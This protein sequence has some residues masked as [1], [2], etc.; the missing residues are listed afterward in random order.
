MSQ[1]DIFFGGTPHFP[2][3]RTTDPRSSHEA[4][5]LVERTGI[6]GKQASAVLAA[7]HGLDNAT[8]A[9]LAKHAG[10][11]RYMVARRAP[12]LA[13]V[14]LID[15]VL[16]TQDTVPCEVSGKRVVRWRLR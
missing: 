16:P 5:Y 3:V 15:K 7:L 11:D 2:R 13:E 9:E 12:E 14:G 6:A 8:S 10:L 1:L 4:A